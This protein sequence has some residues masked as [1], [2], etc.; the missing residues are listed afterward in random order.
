VSWAERTEREP[1]AE[2]FDRLRPQD[3]KKIARFVEG[4]C[5]I[6]LP[7]GKQ[8]MVEGRLRRRVRALGLS[9]LDEYCHH[10]F[11]EGALENEVV[12]LV[13]AITTNKT[14][15]FRE[16]EHFRFLVA[17][18]IPDL[19]TRGHRPGLDRPLKI[20]SAAASTGAEPYTIA[21][22]CDDYG[23]ALRG[24]RFSI[25]ATDICV[26]VLEKAK[27][28]IYPADMMA[29]VP[30]DFLQRYFRRARDPG[31]STVRLIPEIRQMVRFGRL[32]LMEP[33]YPIDPDM[34]IVFCRNILI[35]FDKTTQEA[36]LRKICHHLRPGG[37]LFL[38]HSES[39][40][41][42]S[43]PVRAVATATFQKL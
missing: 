2:S 43:L 30:T 38:G 31:N 19:L 5:G 12:N 13:D 37:Y 8:T 34:D 42:M 11:D 1:S 41:G 16:V 27:A 21:M 32:N 39:I 23:H 25:L 17:H 18:A 26:D 35:Y 20:W 36:V 9:S 24:F 10:L 4:Y 28:G 6:R 14:E 40:A 7:P 22:M 15:F 3:F 29:P 33:H